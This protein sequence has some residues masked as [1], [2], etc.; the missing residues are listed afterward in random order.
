MAVNT[1]LSS[2]ATQF[3]LGAQNNFGTDAGAAGRDPAHFSSWLWR[4]FD[5][6]GYE[7]TRADY[8]A[9]VDRE[10]NAE[11]AA[12]NRDFTAAEAQKNRDFQERMS[13]TAYQRAVAD[14]KAAGINPVMA[15]NQGGAS[16]PSGAAASGSQAS[17]SGNRYV[18][19][20]DTFA[21]T[22]ARGLSDFLGGLVESGTDFALRTV[23]PMKSQSKSKK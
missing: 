17:S 15:A 14:M 6:P 16:T 19:D 5:R 2:G 23:V 13:N 7:E 9:A 20:K 18:S 22:F 1:D 4:V 21:V 3:G 8:L 12:V 11:Q 10:F